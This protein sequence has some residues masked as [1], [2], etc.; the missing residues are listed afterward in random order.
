MAGGL[1][2][3]P[4]FYTNNAKPTGRGYG[5]YIDRLKQSV[6]QAYEESGGEKVILMAHSAGGWLARAAMSDGVWSTDADG[7]TVRT[8]DKIQCLVTLGAIHKVPE[9]ESTCVTRGCL[10]YTDN[11]FPGAF[12]SDEGVKYVT[13]GGASVFNDL[14]T[15]RCDGSA[16]RVACHSYEAVAGKR[17]V[18]G[19]G[20]VPF[21]WTKL[22]RETHVELQGVAHSINKV[23]TTIATKRWYGSENVIDRWL[24]IVLEETGLSKGKGSS[25]QNGYTEIPYRGVPNLSR[26]RLIPT[27]CYP[28]ISTAF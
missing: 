23:G 17:D 6:D 24:P 12:L 19:D 13:V 5:W 15:K 8:S 16:A 25:W 14:H 28:C 4:A 20:V 2:D 27:L 21:E 18:I 3:I 1:L 22:E 7:E 10:K 9:D 11:E 26:R